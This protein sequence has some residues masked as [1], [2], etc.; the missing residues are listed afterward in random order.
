MFT[1]LSMQE[2][3]TVLDE[4]GMWRFGGGFG[5]ARKVSAILY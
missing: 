2:T 1:Y 4:D 3:F 5:V